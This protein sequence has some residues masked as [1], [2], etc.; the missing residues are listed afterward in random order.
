MILTLLIIGHFVIGVTFYLS[1]RKLFTRDGSTWTIEN[2]AAGIVFGATPIG[3]IIFL[4]MVV[5]YLSS[6][7][8]DWDKESKW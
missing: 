2:R 8:I 3:N 1:M 4:I 6:Q 5:C 7:W